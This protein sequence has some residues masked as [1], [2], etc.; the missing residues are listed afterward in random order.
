M[1]TAAS[2]LGFLM[3]LYQQARKGVTVLVMVIDLDYQ[4]E[5]GQVLHRGDEDE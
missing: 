5:T 1:K 4:G 2:H 3:P